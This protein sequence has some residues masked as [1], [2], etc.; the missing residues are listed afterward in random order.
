[1]RVGL[2][3]AGDVGRE[4][5]PSTGRCRRVVSEA[6][7]SWV[8]AASLLM[9]FRP[10]GEIC[11]CRVE[12]EISP[13]GRNGKNAAGALETRPERHAVGTRQ[14]GSRDDM[15]PDREIQPGRHAA[16]TTE[17]Q[18]GRHA[19]R[20]TGMRS[21]RQRRMRNDRDS[22]PIPEMQAKWLRG[23]R[24]GSDAIGAAGRRAGAVR[25][26]GHG[27][28]PSPYPFSKACCDESAILKQAPPPGTGTYSSV[29]SL[30][31]HSSW[32]M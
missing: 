30:A 4:V 14:R 17:I 3:G 13:F 20:T 11:C 24:N 7:A 2:R 26:S 21:K 6:E 16:R 27:K 15:R 22:I 29:A 31:R 1:V 18:P 32:A 19:A 25:T 23:R 28:R 5:R 10:K 8:P 9:S 12:R